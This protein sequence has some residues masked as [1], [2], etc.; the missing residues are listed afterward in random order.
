MTVR[1]RSRESVGRSGGEFGIA[2]AGELPFLRSGLWTDV[3][4]GRQRRPPLTPL[5][6]VLLAEIAR[7][8]TER[9][10]ADLTDAHQLMQSAALQLNGLDQNV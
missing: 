7:R 9:A 3:S 4:G 2:G 10:G 1:A 5:R 8:A 6:L